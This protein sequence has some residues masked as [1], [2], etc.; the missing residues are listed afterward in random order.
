M[1]DDELIKITTRKTSDLSS[2]SADAK[3]ARLENFHDLSFSS[4]G[5]L[6]DTFRGGLRKDLSAFLAKGDAP[7][8]VVGGVTRKGV[9]ADTPIL[10]SLKLRALSPQFGLLAK[11][12]DL[13]ELNTSSTSGIE[14]I[15]PEGVSNGVNWSFGN[16]R[17]QHPGSGIDLSRQNTPPIHP[18]MIDAG[19]SYGASIFKKSGPDAN[20]D[21]IYGVNIHYFPRVVLWNP[22]NVKLSSAA[23]AVQINMP[24]KGRMHAVSGSRSQS[25]SLAPV[26]IKNAPNSSTRPVFSIP[27]T[28]FEPGEALLFT[29]DAG[30]ASRG[31]ILWDTTKRN[32][33]D[34]KLSCQQSPPL[35]GNFYFDTK[36]TIKLKN[37]ELQDLAYKIE[38]QQDRKWKLYFYK[39][40]LAK[41]GGNVSQVLNNPTSFPPLQYISQTEDGSKGTDAPWFNGIPPS[42]T[43]PLRE[44]KDT[45]VH[46]YYRF[47]WGHRMQWLNETNENQSIKPGSYNTPYLGYNTL[48]NHNMRAGWHV[49][50]PVEV[51]FR[52]TA[53]AG[54]YTHGI[55]IDDPY[56]WDWYD[57][58]L[59]PVPVGGKN[60]VSPFGRS[61]NF[62][63]Q[64][65]PILDVPSPTSPLTSLAALQHA[66]LSQFAWHP[67]NAVANSLADPRVPRNQSVHFVSDEQWKNIGIHNPNPDRWLRIRQG[68]INSNLNDAAFL[69]D[70]SYESNDALWDQYYLS[71]VPKSG[72]TQGAPLANPRMILP[73]S[74]DVDSELKDFH[75]SA[76]HFQIK[77]AFNI[78]S[79]SEKAWAVLIASLRKTPDME[80]TLQDG[81]KI[82][83]NDVYSRFFSPYDLKYENNDPTDEKTWKGYRQLTDIQIRDLAKEIVKEVKQ[84]GPFISLADFVNRRL[85]EPPETSGSE[86]A[87]SRTG[88]KGAL[89]A[90]ID[91]TTINSKPLSQHVIDKTE[92]NMGG[93]IP[94]WA[95]IEYGSSYPEIIYPL[96]S[97]SSVMGSKPD[98]NHW[99]DSKMVGAP[100]YLTQ[101][102]LLQKWGGVISARSDTFIIRTYGDAKDATGVIRAKAW[103]E[104]TV[105][106]V[107][108]PMVP[109][110]ANLDSEPDVVAHP[111]A[112]FGRKFKIISFR[113]LNQNEI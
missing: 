100:S 63:G 69:Y 27:S 48:A 107:S 54:R 39:L 9:K 44:F 32:L 26:W 37:N 110:A 108:E 86:T 57:G 96:S 18:I 6:T 67:T 49:V 42:A 12:N 104:A 106:R 8:L 25:V 89:Q 15:A 94:N 52:A 92:Y 10:D 60:R 93:G 73:T 72:Y 21:T 64:A 19:I 62:G 31:N 36:K 14:P 111:A 23:Y 45:P 90:A 83:A 59:D 24:H 51:K 81:T 2:V 30:N 29:A 28:S 46:T 41:S 76:K 43:S 35:I 85:V 20:G 61:A 56:G 1:I 77:G 88:L 38:A 82:Q 66:P 79:T 55:L 13:A 75:K 71:T 22:Y 17:N 16:D 113:W 103:C 65:F 3:Q 97:G 50:S 11:W 112:V 74:V 80:I 68:H 84:R 58:S 109:D 5:L 40:F 102:D 33:S 4:V 98:H 78:N 105:Q 95:Q 70:L 34:F 87:H 99:A 53:S 91:R 47:K 7:D 101:A